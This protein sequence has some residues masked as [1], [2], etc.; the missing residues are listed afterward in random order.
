MEKFLLARLG[1]YGMMTQSYGPQIRGGE[2][3]AHVTIGVDPVT[4][5]GFEKE[6]VVCFRF[7]DIAR[8][9]KELKVSETAL[10]LHGKEVEVVLHAGT[11]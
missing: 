11:K 1:F 6:I 4:Q 2:S 7:S 5:V 8:F 3:A 9:T 10:V